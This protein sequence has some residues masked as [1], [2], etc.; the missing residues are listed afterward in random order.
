MHTI[1]ES[2]VD[3]G[4]SLS[5]CP[6]TVYRPSTS[7]FDK[8]SVTLIADQSPE[9]IVAAL[10]AQITAPLKPPRGLQA[11]ASAILSI[12]FDYALNKFDDTKDRLLAGAPKFLSVIDYHLEKRAVLPMCLPAFPFKS[13]NKVSKVLGSLPDK[14]EEL[15]L[16][17]LNSMC[18]RIATLY[19]PGAKVT[20]VSDGVAYNGMFLPAFI[21]K[22]AD[23][24]LCP[25]T[26]FVSQIVI[27]GLMVRHYAP[28]PRRK[29]TFISN[30]QGWR[31]FSI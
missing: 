1:K 11:P 4:V 18:V 29:D 17:R 8:S 19:P 14:A 30:S 16:D 10:P 21:W 2:L 9:E 7:N 20:I 26:C 12:I 23:T 27:H 22:R 25:K 15:A 31:T 3:S 24:N 6:M 13:A 5:S 28:W